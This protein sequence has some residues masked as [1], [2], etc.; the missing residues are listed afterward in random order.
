MTFYLKYRP[1]AVS[2]LDLA[3]VRKEL[4]AILVTGSF[5][6]AYLFSGPR[7]TGKTSA[8]RILAKVVNCQRNRSAVESAKKK[9]LLEPCNK[10]V[11]CREIA[12]G[13]AL[14]LMEIDAASNRGIDDIRELREKIKLAP[15]QSRFKVYI[16]DEVH[17]LTMEAFNA[18]LKTLEEPPEHALFLLCTTEPEKIPETIISRCTRVYFNR[19][20][21]E[22]VVNSLKKVIKGEEIKIEEGVLQ[23]I[24]AVADGSFRDAMKILEQLAS[25]AKGRGGAKAK[26]KAGEAKKALGLSASVSAR[27][28]IGFLADYDRQQVF[29]L[30]DRVKA[31]GGSFK[32][33][34]IESLELLRLQMLGSLGVVEG[35]EPISGLELEQ[36]KQLVRLLMNAGYELKTSLVPQLP[37]EMAVVEWLALGQSKDGG[38]EGLGS[39]EEIGTETRKRL[40]AKEA[41]SEIKVEVKEKREAE[42]REKV[43]G[44]KQKIE[45]SFSEVVKNWPQ[46]LKFIAFKN[47]SIEALLRLARPV[48]INDQGLVVEVCY[49]FH[50]EQLELSRYKALVETAISRVFASGL[51]LSY[52]LSQSPVKGQLKT[53][54]AFSGKDENLSGR[55]EDEEIIRAVEEIFS[56]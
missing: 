33:L 52:V 5:S 24:G 18:L 39:N 43:N 31:E 36:I 32:R 48:A 20:T 25:G 26:V 17:M 1:Q 15:S 53:A 4:K 13:I 9:V 38:A 21:D 29:A 28:F 22:E 12:S 50:K 10:C 23:E 46:V 44:G 11:S 51:R 7:G 3:S 6:H 30:I 47:Q 55:V 16:I 2:Q 27:K 42:G 54:Q 40:P 14:D 8:A 56:N 49:K 41:E 45:V 19:A 37:L 34:I 35:V